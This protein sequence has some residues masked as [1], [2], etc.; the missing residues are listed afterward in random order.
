MGLERSAEFGS[1]YSP[2]SNDRWQERDE[3]PNVKSHVSA[4][5]SSLPPL[6]PSSL[7]R[8]L[9]CR[10]SFHSHERMQRGS[11][12]P[13]Y[14]HS[15]QMHWHADR[16]STSPSVIPSILLLLAI[17]P[18]FTWFLGYNTLLGE[19]K[20]P[21]RFWLREHTKSFELL[22]FWI[23]LCYFVVF[24]AM[25]PLDDGWLNGLR[26]F[27]LCGRDTHHLSS[28]FNYPSNP[29]LTIKRN[30]NEKLIWTPAGYHTFWANH[31]QEFVPWSSCYQSSGW[32]RRFHPERSNLFV[33]GPN[34]HISLFFPVVHTS[35]PNASS[36]AAG[37]HSEL[38]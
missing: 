29:V 28:C 3:R 22:G 24:A 38:L 25:R 7:P 1:Q 17:P 33:F 30:F 23:I 11:A 9:S 14:I 2:I 35:V 10:A 5:L 4:S 18:F 26:N 37:L 13:V 27:S 8:H 21:T 16:D 6:L 36:Y 19:R 15:T 20:Q 32:C 12:R 31:K 34:S